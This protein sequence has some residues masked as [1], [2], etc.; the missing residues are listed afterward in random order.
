MKWEMESMNR[1]RH[2]KKA[3]TAALCVT[4]TA[5]SIYPA[6]AAGQPM[7]DEN[8]Y[9]NLNQDGS[10]SDI[11]VVNEYMLDEDCVIEDYGDYTNLKN[12]SSKIIYPLFSY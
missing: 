8:V 4:L 3:A 9:V 10:V 11:Y 12:L 5:G 6:A 2:L 7:K 1:N